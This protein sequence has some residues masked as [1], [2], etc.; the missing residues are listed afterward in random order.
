MLIPNSS[1]ALFWS[2]YMPD[3]DGKI[4]KA[5]ILLNATQTTLRRSSLSCRLNISRQH[6]CLPRNY[7]SCPLQLWYFPFK[8][9]LGFI[10]TFK[11]DVIWDCKF[12]E[13]C[14]YHFF[15]QKLM[16]TFHMNRWHHPKSP[17]YFVKFLIVILFDLT[18]WSMHVWAS[19]PNVDL[20]LI[21]GSY[22]D[23]I[24]IIM[25]WLW[26]LIAETFLLNLCAN[27]NSFLLKYS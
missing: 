12:L 6:P 5:L 25:K 11:R 8:A 19:L 14:L 2:L 9:N 21:Y 18:L 15:H 4:Y 22:W 27:W 1:S 3:L 23:I 20:I 10:I 7:I 17:N 16:P 13:N 24:L 26:L